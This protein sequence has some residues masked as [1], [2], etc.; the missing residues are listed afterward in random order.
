MLPLLL[1]ILCSVAIAAILRFSEGRDGDRYVVAGANYVVAGILSMMLMP[2]AASAAGSGQIAFGVF[3]GLGFVGGFVS[4]MAA[5][6]R[7]GMAVPATTARISTLIPVLGSVILYRETPSA[8][9]IAGIVTGLAA[10]V[11]LGMAQRRQHRDDGVGSL[12]LWLLAAVFVIAGTI[13]F[14]LK[15]AHESGASR[16]PFL[17]IVFG[18][19]CAVC[20]IIVLIG[21][22]R[23][24]GRDLLVGAVLGIPN[25]GASYFLLQAL[26]ELE[27]VVVFPTANAAIVLGVTAVAILGWRERPS[28]TTVAGLALAAA[29]VV[30]L[31][32]G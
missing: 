3:V 31:G 9:Q 12:A 2:P 23:V 27:G 29:A 16:G 24:T 11:V 8:L 22:R 5:M 10:F 1:T 20:W 25:F 19:A 17:L 26:G 4:L 6:N 13:D 30:L 15:I 21:R 32:L 14:A 28:P 18:T 7:I